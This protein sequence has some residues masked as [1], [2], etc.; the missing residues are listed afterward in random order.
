M[1][2]VSV[3]L[4]PSNN[5]LNNIHEQA[6]R[7]IYNDHEKSFNSIL[8]E[9]D[10]KAI[11]QKYFEFL[12]IGK[13]FKMVCTSLFYFVLKHCIGGLVVDLA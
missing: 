8:K 2:I 11:H 4:R 7:L 5:A 10:L 12:A 6:L 13:K 1:E 3:R 9:D